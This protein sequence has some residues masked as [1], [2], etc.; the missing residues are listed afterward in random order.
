MLTAKPWAV[1]AILFW[2]YVVEVM[3]KLG[4]DVHPWVT[5]VAVR[6]G[7]ALLGLP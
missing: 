1:K 2:V 6:W 3:V 7:L 4:A 5:A